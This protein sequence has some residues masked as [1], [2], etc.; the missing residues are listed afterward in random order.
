M[1]KPGKWKGWGV[2]SNKQPNSEIPFSFSIE[3]TQ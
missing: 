2:R 3:A 1:L